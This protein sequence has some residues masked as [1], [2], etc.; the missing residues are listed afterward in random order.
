[1]RSRIY[2]PVIVTI[3]LLLLAGACRKAGTWLVKKD[4]PGQGDT[5]GQVDAMVMLMGSIP[6]RVLQTADLYGRRVAGKVVVV[7][8]SVG[9]YRVLEERGAHI[10]SNSTQARNALVVLGIPEDSIVILPGDATSTQMEA[11]II[12]DYLANSPAIETVLLVS[13]PA[14]TRRASMIFRAAFKSLEHPV[15][16]YCSPS[17]YTTFY[18]EKWWRSREDIQKVLMEYLKLGNFVLFERRQLRRQ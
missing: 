11:E 17:S 18:A 7:E 5:P 14:H 12:R 16:V 2:I 13:S 3:V 9:A 10:I 4:V 8:E 1:M 15:G 6:D